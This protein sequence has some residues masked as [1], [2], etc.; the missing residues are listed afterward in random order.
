MV[1]GMGRF[2]TDRSSAGKGKLVLQ[3]LI[4]RVREL[5]R[6]RRSQIDHGLDKA[7]QAISERTGGKYD[8]RIDTIRQKADETLNE[9]ESTAPDSG[10]NP[11]DPGDPGD[12]RPNR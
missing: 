12:T 1:P 10:T 7:E 9:N 3:N 11:R 6:G 5:L 2:S 8:D 4:A